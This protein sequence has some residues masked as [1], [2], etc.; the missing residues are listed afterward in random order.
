MRSCIKC[1]DDSCA[2]PDILEL[3]A[4]LKIAGEQN[5]L[6]LLCIL[7]DGGEHCVCEFGDHAADLSQ[8]LIS[9]HLAD[10]KK[11]GLIMS[12]KR[13]LNVHYALTERGTLVADTLFSLNNRESCVTKE[14]PGSKL[15]CCRTNVS[16]ATVETDGT[17]SCKDAYTCKDCDYRNCKQTS[18]NDARCCTGSKN[19]N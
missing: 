15:S 17:C 4:L 6:R 5:R 16:A 14:T 2:A 12:E 1:S 3:S 13:G 19:D 10:L 8:S 7:R 9:H 11:A 18:R